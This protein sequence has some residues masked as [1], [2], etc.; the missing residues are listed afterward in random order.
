MGSTKKTLVTTE[1]NCAR[2]EAERGKIAPAPDVLINKDT[3]ENRTPIAVNGEIAGQASE[4][5]AQNENAL[6]G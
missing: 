1:Q 2:C 3:A 5:D 6:Q 4:R